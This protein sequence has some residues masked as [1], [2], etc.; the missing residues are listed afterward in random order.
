MKRLPPL[1]LLLLAAWL[2]APPAAAGPR[3]VKVLPQFVDAQ[4]RAALSPSL[5]ERDAYQAELRRDDARRAGVRFAVEANGV[6]RHG[7]PLVLRLE[8]RGTQAGLGGAPL[9]IEA[10]WRPRTLTRT[11]A[12]VSLTGEDYR[13]LGDLVAW[14]A[15]LR[16][17]DTVVAEQKSFL[18]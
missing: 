9:V 1:L 16:D 7:R 8:L 13:R 3:I 11:W 14:R 17:G 12:D 6:R 15:T 18:W 4:G 2:P 5:Y 10:P